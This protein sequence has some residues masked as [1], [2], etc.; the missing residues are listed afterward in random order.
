MNPARGRL[1]R[2]DAAD[3]VGHFDGTASQLAAARSG[4]EPSMITSAGI[5]GKPDSRAFPNTRYAP[6]SSFGMSRGAV[7]PRLA[8]RQGWA[9]ARIPH[10]K[11]IPP[12]LP[13]FTFHAVPDGQTH[14]SRI[15]PIA[16]LGYLPAPNRTKAESGKSKLTA[17]TQ[18]KE[19]KEE[20]AHCPLPTAHCHATTPRRNRRSARLPVESRA[21]GCG[22]ARHGAG[23]GCGAICP[24]RSNDRPRGRVADDSRRTGTAAVSAVG[25]GRAC[26]FAAGG[27]GR[28]VALGHQCPIGRGPR[29]GVGGRSRLLRRRATGRPRRGDGRFGLLLRP[30]RSGPTRSRRNQRQ[31]ASL[32]LRPGLLGSRPLVA[33]GGRGRPGNG[34]HGGSS[35]TERAGFRVQGSGF[36]TRKA[37]LPQESEP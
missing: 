34:P 25:L 16:H 21:G 19:G 6:L 32:V 5:S 36:S 3:H 11:P 7:D 2:G 20:T 31:H 33:I 4:F 29:D 27:G 37:R 26:R 8:R 10:K 1:R 13:A 18:R 15:D 24:D 17:K 12:G 35:A 9:D 22:L 23:Q 28:A 14:D 30:S